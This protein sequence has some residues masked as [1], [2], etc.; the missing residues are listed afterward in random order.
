MVGRR[1]FAVCARLLVLIQAIAENEREHKKNGWLTGECAWCACACLSVFVSVFVSLSLCV[2]EREQ[3][4]AVV[5]VV[6]ESEVQ[7]PR[8]GGQLAKSLRASNA[9]AEEAGAAGGMS[10]S[11]GEAGRV[12]HRGLVLQL[13]SEKER[14]VWHVIYK[15]RKKER[16]GSNNSKADAAGDGE[17]EKAHEL[18]RSLCLRELDVYKCGIIASIYS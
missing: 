5:L 8:I 16:E 4:L 3:A 15:Q 9:G 17:K 10:R 2:R 11:G 14:R 7:Y 18:D 1:V 12:A 6:E 13:E